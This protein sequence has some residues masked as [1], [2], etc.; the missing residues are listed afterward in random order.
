MT[1]VLTLAAVCAVAQTQG[2][3]RPWRRG[4]LT[5]G[6]FGAAPY[7]AREASHLEYAVVFSASGV[8]EG[9]DTYRYCRTSAVMYPAASWLVDDSTTENELNY[10]QMLFDVVEVHR[11]QMQRTALMLGGKAQYR[12]LQGLTMEALEREVAQLRLATDE[13]RDSAAVERVRQRNRE[14]LNAHPGERPVF[15]PRSWWWGMGLLYGAA[16]PTGAMGRYWSASIGT[17]G[18][19]F[20][21]GWN[22]HGIRYR[23][24]GGDV[25]V[26]D[27]NDRSYAYYGLA[28]ESRIDV[29]FGYGYTLI[30][31]PAWSLTPY[32]SIGTTELGWWYAPS[33]TLGVSGLYHLHRWHRV[34]NAVKGKARSATVSAT[35]DLS[36]SY[37]DLD[38]SKGLT[39]SLQIGIALVSR[40]EQVVW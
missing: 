21:Y 40:K 5:V 4:P 10:N 8:T 9:L 25:R 26:L 22:R 31:R 39:F 30:E 7:G 36:V 1:V 35:A 6:D 12:R 34:V 16:V 20:A 29:S 15:T 11:R 18:F 14:W 37:A 23:F 3:G 38:A 2:H 27:T 24:S 32:V 17:Q 13:G 19:D 33:Y 28:T